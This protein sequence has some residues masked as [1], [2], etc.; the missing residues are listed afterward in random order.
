MLH[1]EK[2][3]KLCKKIFLEKN[4]DYG[5]SWQILRLAS[6]TDQIAIKARRIRSIQE[7]KCQEIED[8]IESEL[9][10]IVNYSIM[11]LMKHDFAGAL[12]N[13]P[14]VKEI[15]NLYDSIVDSNIKL[16]NK[17]NHDYEEAW[18]HMRPGSMVDIILMK[19]LRIKFI[20]DNGG[21]T[22]ISEGIDANYRD[23]INYAVFCLILLDS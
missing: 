21:R 19:V 15:D 3:L 8:S 10:G 17:K 5:S 12:T 6:I 2:I 9:I 14:T 20:E 23:I 4:C 18:R 22:S 16:L 11:A 7:K 1:F 13:S